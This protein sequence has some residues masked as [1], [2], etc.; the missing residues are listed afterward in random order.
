[1]LLCSCLRLEL[2]SR[3]RTGEWTSDGGWQE[4]QEAPLEMHASLQQIPSASLVKVQAGWLF[5]SSPARWKALRCSQKEVCR[6]SSATSA[7]KSR[8]QA[9]TTGTI[10]IIFTTASA[11][12]EQG[13]HAVVQQ[14]AGATHM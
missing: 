6:Q 7:A 13:M 5:H 4:L 3:L 12:T 11:L 1:M 10:F 9:M 2:G 8:Q 14:V